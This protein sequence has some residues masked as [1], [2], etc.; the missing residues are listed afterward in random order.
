MFFLLMSHLWFHN[1]RTITKICRSKD[2]SINQL[3]LKPK[4]Y[5]VKLIRAYSGCLGIRRRW[6][7][8][9]PAK[10]DGELDMSF[11]PLISEWGNPVQV[12]LHHPTVNQYAVE[13][14]HSGNWNILVPEGKERKSIPSVA[15][16]ESGTAQTNL[17][18][19]VTDH[20]IGW[21]HDSW[22][23]WESQS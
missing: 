5:E 4:F 15:A 7:T 14:V 3:K 17:R 1:L 22:M 19:G 9:L 6:R 21:E 11:D 8:R 10:S 13:K 16:S 23:A 2:L 18:I 20:D 12:I